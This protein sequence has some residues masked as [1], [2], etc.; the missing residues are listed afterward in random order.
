[1][2]EAE[3]TLSNNAIRDLG[4]NTFKTT[5]ELEMN[6]TL[7]HNNDTT[8]GGIVEKRVCTCTHKKQGKGSGWIEHVHAKI[9]KTLVL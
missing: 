1:M 2:G 6:G 3:N 7:I 9:E 4:D 8:H 5:T